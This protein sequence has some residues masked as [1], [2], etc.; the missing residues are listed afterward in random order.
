YLINR[1]IKSDFFN[2]F[3]VIG[4]GDAGTAW[5]GL[6]PYS[7]QN[8]LNETVVSAPGN[9]ITVTLSTLQDPFVE[10]VGYGLRTRVFGYFIRFDDA[11]GISNGSFSKTDIKYFSLSLDF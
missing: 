1:P 10:G 7:S 9:P 5:T 8:A 2:N 6:T 4:F 11:W 3:Q